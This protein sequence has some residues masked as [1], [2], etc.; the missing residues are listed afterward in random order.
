M[1]LRALDARTHLFSLVLSAVKCDEKRLL[2]KRRNTKGNKT[3]RSVWYSSS[4]EVF[5]A[6]LPLP[7]SLLYLY[8]CPLSNTLRRELWHRRLYFCVDLVNLFGLSATVNYKWDSRI[9]LHTVVSSGVSELSQCHPP[10]SHWTYFQLP[11]TA[12]L[13]LT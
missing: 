4:A 8:R 10:V 11:N 5:L 7:H 12:L 6:A 3:K 1:P 2:S 13:S 9:L